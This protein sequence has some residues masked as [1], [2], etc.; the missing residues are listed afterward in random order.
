MTEGKKLFGGVLHI[1]GDDVFWDT[2]HSE[3]RFSV[4]SEY[5]PQRK[6]GTVMHKVISISSDGIVELR[7]TDTGRSSHSQVQ[8]FCTSYVVPCKK[9]ERKAAR[10]AEAERKKAAKI[11]AARQLLEQTTSPP[12]AE[13][14][15]AATKEGYDAQ[16]LWKDL[17]AL[18]HDR[19]Q[20][21][22]NRLTTLIKLR[23]ESTRIWLKEELA[24]QRTDTLRELGKIGTL[25]IEQGS[26]TEGKLTAA[27]IKGLS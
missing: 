6:E 15:S 2:R 26:I 24:A 11:A 1:D 4:G 22:E 23:D 9:K 8:N 25:L 10:L 19:M 3:Y 16:E 7:R 27:I 12:A 14:P 20:A 17:A 18:I 5:P 13:A 21:L